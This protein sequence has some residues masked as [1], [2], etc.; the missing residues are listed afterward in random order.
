MSSRHSGIVL[1]CEEMMKA[2]API[3]S[4]FHEGGAVFICYAH[5]DNRDENVKLRWLDRL[6]EFL[7]PLVRQHHLTTWSDRDVKIGERWHRRIQFQLEVSRAIL[8][9]ISPA[10][11][12]S[13]YIATSEL[14]VL[15]KNAAD[16]GSTILPLIISPCLY[17]EAIFKFPDPTV[18]PDILK[19]SSLQASNPPSRTLIEMSEAE[20]N[21]TLLRV[22]RRLQEIALPSEYS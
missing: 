9:L 19:L 17:E 2:G 22:A 16:R 6:L 13:E 12:A 18:G 20:Q 1:V 5:A 15:L 4:I 21:R 3:S 10:F 7:H 14:P 11:L 8:L